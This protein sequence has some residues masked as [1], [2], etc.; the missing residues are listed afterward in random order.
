M[1][2]ITFIVPKISKSFPKATYP[3]KVINKVGTADA[4]EDFTID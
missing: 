3:L 2:S 4:P 1:D